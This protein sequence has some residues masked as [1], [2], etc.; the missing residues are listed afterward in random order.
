MTS[1]VLNHVWLIPQS[2]IVDIGLNFP[3]I[4]INEILLTNRD[5]E[6]VKVKEIKE[7]VLTFIKER[8][9][10]SLSEISEKFRLDIVE[11]KQV[12]NELEKD[13]KI[14]VNE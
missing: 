5:R 2:K 8:K 1:E 12:I 11:A 6:D 9:R 14:R 4:A 7:K 13:G 10:V 3:T